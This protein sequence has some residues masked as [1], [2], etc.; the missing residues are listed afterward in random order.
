MEN[1]LNQISKLLQLI[2]NA[3]NPIVKKTL[4]LKLSRFPLSETEDIFIDLFEALRIGV[5]IICYY[6]VG[7]TIGQLG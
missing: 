7:P 6:F 4:I 2:E 5:V 3:P 1:E